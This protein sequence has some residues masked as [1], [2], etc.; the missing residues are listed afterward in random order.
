MISGKPLEIYRDK[1]DS[2][3]CNQLSRK[4]QKAVDSLG[5]LE[6]YVG[7]PASRTLELTGKVEGS[8]SRK[9]KKIPTCHLTLFA[10]AA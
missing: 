10:L 6:I 4:L 2:T 7:K 1:R 9:F 3:L 8:T 5:D